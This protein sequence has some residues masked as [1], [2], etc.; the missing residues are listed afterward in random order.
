MYP[1]SHVVRVEL[2]EAQNALRQAQG[3]RWVYLFLGDAC[4][5]ADTS[6]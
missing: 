4:Q 5:D 2:V 1:T 6:V 3:E